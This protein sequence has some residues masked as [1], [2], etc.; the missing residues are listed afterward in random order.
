MS[1]GPEPNPAL[2]AIGEEE[3][4]VLARVREAVL[5][6]AQGW[7][8]WS[9]QVEYGNLRELREAAFEGSTE[10]VPTL[11]TQMRV[12]Q[13]QAQRARR[14]PLPDLRAPYFA[15]MRVRAGERVRELLLGDVT[16]WDGERGVTVL[17]WRTS[18][19]ATVF[20]HHRQG[21]LYEEDFEGRLAAGR[22]ELRRV[23][24]FEDGE[25]RQVLAP[26]GALRR[27]PDGTWRE[28]Q[29]DVLPQLAAG[30]DATESPLV[31]GGQRGAGRVQPVVTALLDSAQ[32][33]ALR[34][35][36]ERPLLI[37]GSAG[38]GKTTVALHRMAVL[39]ARYP[40]RFPP[41]QMAV[42]V[43]QPGLVRLT[44]L[45]LRGLGLPR[46]VVRTYDAWVA[47]QARVAF[48]GLP[49]RLCEDSPYEALRFKRHP[50]LLE[51]LPAVVE[52]LRD[53][54]GEELDR[55]FGRR[56]HVP[57]LLREACK[58]TR[59]LL[60]ALQQVERRLYAEVRPRLK[61]D[62]RAALRRARKRLDDVRLDREAVLLDR[63]LLL[64][65]VRRS[66][67]ELSEADAEAVLS[68]GHAQLGLSETSSGPQAVD[69]ERMRSLDGRRAGQRTN[70]PRAGTMDVEDLALLFA[71]Q[72]LK[73]GRPRTRFG[74]LPTYALLLI[75]EAQDLAPAELSLL[76]QSLGR[77]STLLV[78][79]D[80]AQQ[81]DPS[82]HFDS[83]E[84]LMDNLGAHT[85]SNSVTLQTA[86]R[87]PRPIARYAQAVLGPLAPATPPT[88]HR[89][90]APVL[91][92]PQPNLGRAV[93]ALSE[94][95][96]ELLDREPAATVAVICRRPD[97]AAAL[98]KVL[99][100]GLP[101]RLVADG[102]FTFRAGIEVTDVAQVKGLEFDYV[103]VPDASPSTYPDTPE[104]RR[105]LHVAV[106]RA[107]HQL[108]VLSVAR[109]APILP[110]ASSAAANGG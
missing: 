9:P 29:G 55:F 16:F 78:A 7:R 101:A 76:G 2:L 85:G 86:Y 33:E 67:G 80:A 6:R 66:G 47:E 96:G 68:H 75:D 109:P 65:A 73:V 56:G 97:G 38:C 45:L 83:W 90:G 32:F 98:H 54:L 102:A 36:P 57:A 25:L 82:A 17:N 93:A 35:D 1:A 84:T 103:V 87:S 19:M 58:R 95:L 110:P 105:A 15:R 46:V 39:A 21:E 8:Q 59:H 51:A 61:A 23:V 100:A 88:A 99:S 28:A 104:S 64:D 40:E 13:R 18:P 5:A 42:V 79:G 12:V 26:E 94:G 24:A 89:D 63:R 31:R 22:L 62:L 74:G 50:A 14:T 81:V 41:E 44:E 10:D 91:Y 34:S 108:W 69:P 48:R 11:V 53:E 106:T 37:L 43:P 49:Q 20:F 92:T 3:E 71:L 27:G 52:R 4:R 30:D 60:A 77:R 70:D 107:I 72:R